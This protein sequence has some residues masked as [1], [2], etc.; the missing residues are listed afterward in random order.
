MSA[1]IDTLSP[2]VVF[3]LQKSPIQPVVD[4][5]SVDFIATF[6]THPVLDA[7]LDPHRDALLVLQDFM[8]SAS[9]DPGR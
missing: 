8:I 5:F 3:A 2:A 4:K 6:G 9:S 1:W 7:H